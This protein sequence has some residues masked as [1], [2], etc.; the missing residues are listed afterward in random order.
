MGTHLSA[1][2]GINL[3]MLFC[4]CLY[5]N[6]SSYLFF[7][8]QKY[9]E[10]FFFM[11]EIRDHV[12]FLLTKKRIFIYFSL[13]LLCEGSSKNKVA[14]CASN[15]THNLEGGKGMLRFAE[16]VTDCRRVQL[17]HH[18]GETLSPDCCSPSCCDN[19]LAEV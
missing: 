10:L 7:T 14:A 16:N 9:F 13:S 4:G 5:S 6:V 1:F 2:F 17:L 3:K 8:C 11:S 19:Y 15:E 12:M 18:F